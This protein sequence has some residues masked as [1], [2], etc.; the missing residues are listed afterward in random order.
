MKENDL[1]KGLKADWL[2]KAN[3]E[4]NLTKNARTIGFGKKKPIEVLERYQILYRPFRRVNLDI[5]DARINIQSQV[6][7]LIDEE[8]IGKVQDQNHRLLLWRPK[9]ATLE[10]ADIEGVEFEAV[11]TDVDMMQSIVD[12]I[13]EQR[14]YA[15]TEDDEMGPKLKRMQAD[16]L[17]AIAVIVP[18]SP[19]GLRREQKLID[20]RMESHAYVLATSLVTNCSPKDIITSAKVGERIY[21]ETVIAEYLKN[22]GSRRLVIYE[23][24]GAKTMNE[25]LKAGHAL[26]RL[27][28]LYAECRNVL[29]K[30]T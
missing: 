16:P 11:Y 26:S 22:D 21:A 28:E 20:E 25:A 2:D 6:S 18:R 5:T 7:S 15:Q 30:M 1:A 17:S 29:L 27:C 10:S 8:L 23:T 3:L 12:D 14:W 4:A 9:Y 13:L 24:P 19:G